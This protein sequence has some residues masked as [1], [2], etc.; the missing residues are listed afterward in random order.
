MHITYKSGLSLNP[1][2]LID[3]LSNEKTVCNTIINRPTPQPIKNFD[4]ETSYISFVTRD[5]AL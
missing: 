5:K 2:T 1:V 3:T 4:G